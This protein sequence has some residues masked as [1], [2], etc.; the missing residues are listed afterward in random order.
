MTN[1]KRTHS[2]KTPMRRPPTRVKIAITIALILFLFAAPQ[3]VRIAADSIDI[4]AGRIFYAELESIQDTLYW[5]GL[6]IEHDGT[7]LSESNEPFASIVLDAPILATVQFPGANFKPDGLH[8][9]GATFAEEFLATNI[10]DATPSLLESEQIF[11]SSLYPLLY[12]GYND[13]RD[14]PNQTFC[15]DTAEVRLGGEN[16]TAFRIELD[17]GIDYYLLGYDDGGQLMPLFLV[18]IA[19]A[20][21]YNATACVGQFMV[22]VSPEP[23]NFFAISKM[24]AYTYDIFIDGVPTRD[25]P[26]TG[27]P[28]NLTIV[29]RDL[30]TGVTTPGVNVLVGEENGLNIFVPY[31][32]SGYVSEFYSIGTTGSNGAETFLVTP[33]QYPTIDDYAMYV[34]VLQEGLITSRESLSVLNVDSLVQQSKPLAPS[35]L[36]DNAKTSVNALN[37]IN[38]FLFTWSSQLL[39]AYRYTIQYEL[40]GSSFTVIP[41]HTAGSTFELKTGAPNVINVVVTNGGFPQGGYRARIRETDGYLVMNPYTASAPLTNAD[42]V[43]SS[44]NLPTGNDFIVTPTSL[45]AVSSNITLEII[46]PDGDVIAELPAVIDANLNIGSGGVF[47]NNDLLKTVTNS[48]NQVINSLFYALNF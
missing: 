8:W 6:K 13:K 48:M 22:P 11:P 10:I 37:Q 35:T 31:R 45:G 41:A 9:Y 19:D 16:Y 12:P 46:D 30:Y 40:V 25:F 4:E 43:S 2:A 7:P 14:N 42:R 34:A 29:T 21:C 17:F 32:L 27:L 38:N 39:Q 26:Q 24:R 47:Y 20:T 3:I 18:D 33:T 44:Q 5:A 28:Y 36:F 23:Y 15:C 1:L